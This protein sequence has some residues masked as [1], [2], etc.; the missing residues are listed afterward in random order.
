MEVI[1][2]YLM[3]FAALLL[4][5]VAIS[6]FI[7][8]AL[9]RSKKLAKLGLALAA[10]SLAVLVRQHYS[11]F[12]RVDSCMDSGGRYNYEQHECEF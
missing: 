7:A 11:E 4:L 1:V 12:W 5:P 9:K 10:V 3:F 6:F 2:E 8:A